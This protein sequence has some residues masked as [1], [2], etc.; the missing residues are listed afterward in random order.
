MTRARGR[1]GRIWLDPEAEVRRDE[2][3]KGWAAAYAPRRSASNAEHMAA[4][5]R[6]YVEG[7]FTGASP[8]ARPG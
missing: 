1:V 2:E 5:L 4:Q 8:G 3:P 7:N 6:Q